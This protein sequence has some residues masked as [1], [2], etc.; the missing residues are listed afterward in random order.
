M[1][2]ERPEGLPDG[3]LPEGGMKP[4][5][6]LPEGGMKPDGKVPDGELPAD[7]EPQDIT[8]R[9]DIQRNETEGGLTLSGTYESVPV[10]IRVIRL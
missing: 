7:R 10:S 2:G 5:R 9:D 4:D 8:E 3:E 6:E 1:R